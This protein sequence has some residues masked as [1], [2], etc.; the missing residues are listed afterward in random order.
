MGQVTLYLDR[1]T[2]ARVKAAAKA[3]KKTLS[4]WVAEVLQQRTAREWPASVL[5]LAGAWKD[6]PTAEEIRRSRGRDA[7]RERF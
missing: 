2:E 3:E 6:F 5:D 4:R 1:E 7:R